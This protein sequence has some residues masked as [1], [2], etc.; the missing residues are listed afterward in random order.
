MNLTPDQTVEHLKES[1]AGY[2]ESQYRI[3]H[4]LIFNE[5]ADLLRKT[6]VIAQLPFIEATPAFETEDFLRDL[7]DLHPNTVPQG[8]T[9][10]VD[11]GIPISRYRLYTHQQRALLESFGNRPNLLVATGTGSGKTEAFVL[12]ILARILSEAKGWQAPAERTPIT[13]SYNETY[14]WLHSRRNERRPAAIRALILYPMNALVNDQMSRLRRILSLNNSPDWQRQTL[15]GNLIHFGMYTSLTETTGVPD[16]PHKRKRF[17]DY[18]KQLEEEWGTLSE[19]LQ[20]MGNWP[21]PNE[22]EML[23][24]WDMQ[25]APP[26]ILV[27]NYSMLEYTL[28]RHIERDM[29]D[30]T[31]RWL[32][33]SP[34]NKFTLV[35]DEAHTYTGAKGTEVAHLIRRLKE[36]L[37]IQE[38]DDKLRAIATS[39]SIPTRQQDGARQLRRF[40]ADL[41]GETEESFT[42]IEANVT[43]LKGVNRDHNEISMRAF[44]D[45]HHR[46]STENPWPAMNELARALG[47]PPPNGS[48]D[49]QVAMFSL[50][51]DNEDVRWLRDRTARNA[52]ILDDLSKEFWPGEDCAEDRHQ[53]TSGALAAGAFARPEPV[54]DIQPLLSMRVH[55][56]FRGLTG[57]WACMNPQCPEIDGAYQ[58]ERPLGKLYGDPRV[59]CECGMRVLE[60]FTCR[61][62]GL[63]FLGGFP[64]SGLGSL[65]PWVDEFKDSNSPKENEYIIFGVERPHSDYPQRHRSMVTTRLVAQSLSD[66]RSTYE[67]EPAKDWQTKEEVVPYPD[68]C[69][70]CQNYRYGGG[71]SD[72]PREIIESLSTRGPRSISVVIEDSL[73]VQPTQNNDDQFNAKA[74]IFSDSRQNAAQLAGDLRRDHRNDVFRQLLYRTLHT[75][76]LCSGSGVVTRKAPYVIGQALSDAEVSCTTCSGSGINPVPLPMSFGELRREVLDL[77]LERSINI[78]EEVNEAAG[79]YAF[80][81][82]ENGDSAI[83]REWE[84]AFSVQLNREI[85]QEDFGLEPLGLG[86]WAVDIPDN[87]GTFD[88]LYEDETKKLLRIVTRILATEKVLLPPEPNKPWEWPH[89]ERMQ[90]YER[91]R[92]VIG[93]RAF[94]NYVPYNFGP[95][96]KLG[97]YMKALATALKK[98][99]RITIPDKWLEEQRLKIWDALKGFDILS[100]A[101]KIVN[102][103]A[104]QGIR[105]DK[106][107]LHPI[108]DSVF[109]CRECRYVMGETLFDVCYRCGQ[110]TETAPAQDI[111]NQFRRIALFSLPNSEF[112]DPYAMRAAEHTAQIERREA[113]SIE[114]W[115][116]D[117]F[118]PEEYPADHRVDILSV[119][120]TMEMG[121]DIGSLLSVGLRNMAPNVANYQQRSGRAGRRGSSLATVITYC[122]HR[123][124]DQYYFQ[125]PREIIS[126]PPRAPALYLT[127]EVIARRHVRS[128]VLTEFFKGAAP[129]PNSTHLFRVWGTTGVFL[130][131]GGRESLRKR[132]AADR[133]I[134]IQRSKCVVHQSFHRELDAW[135][136][137]MPEEIERAAA[138]SNYDAD[139]LETLIQKG[140]APKYAFPVDVVRLSIPQEEDYEEPY[141]SQDY[142]SGNTRDRKIAITEYAPGAEVLLSRFPNTFV[143]SVAAVYDP[144]AV[145]PNY[146]PNE[147]LHEC[148]NCRALHISTTDDSGNFRQCIECGDTD[149]RTFRCLIPAGF[150]VDNAD[151]DKARRPYTQSGRARAGFS[152]YAQMLVG[153]GAFQSGNKAP[154]SNGLW[155]NVDVGDLAM[156]NSGPSS[157]DSDGFR[158]CPDCGRMLE[159]GETFHRYPSD[160]PP[161]FGTG[162]GP[163]AG[164][165][166]PNRTGDVNDLT[167]LHRFSSEVITLAVDLPSQLDAPFTDESGR[168]IWHSSATLIKEAAARTLQIDQNEIQSGIRPIR[169]PQGRIQG[170]IFIY[171][172]VPGGAG[173]ARAIHDN[174]EEIMNEALR[175]SRQCSNLDCEDACY[176]CILAYNNQLIHKY[177]DRNLG[178]SFIEFVMTGNMP[179]NN[180]SRVDFSEDI[181]DYLSNS[182]W[183]PAGVAGRFTTPNGAAV[184]IKVIHP[185]MSRPSRDA[186]IRTFTTFDVA[187]RPFWVA[188]RLLKE[189]S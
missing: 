7:E 130:Q 66:S 64:D 6:G 133:E 95:Y 85:T 45:F 101:G 63:L 50:L 92:L 35:L 79:K 69:P 77:Q 36:R 119:T 127:N 176:H 9:E 4:P 74:L 167:L 20:P 179:P 174:L 170:E 168:A 137:E 158:I 21:I 28:I 65:W 134:F 113:R 44:A 143:Y 146:T 42:V 86:M 155:S 51:K 72:N 70:R 12:P 93:Q 48:L 87:S 180:L 5:R 142:Y 116:Q 11:H 98:S 126:E 162:K 114:R 131:R 75:C 61:K 160:V 33:E 121:I 96:R 34:E 175:A 3:S 82:I 129:K 169:D 104:P 91:R 55:I 2:L 118:L 151:L 80:K 152:S 156:S 159:D 81:R 115:F 164:A 185:L 59:R 78:A 97:R 171:D 99:G 14:G 102:N 147:T 110:S 25:S 154:W 88:G 153:Q 58:G 46:F 124:H 10:L 84:T 26:D 24:R 32:A 15:N 29:F 30:S 166:C 52:T 43:E 18:I 37:G 68:R 177:L 23:C 122:L 107:V 108:G 16:N 39:A 111:R 57:I 184:S 94:D 41:F 40:T 100:N 90:R 71:D 138:E 103:Q 38:G 139:L 145:E 27:T 150:S 173:Y 178:R 135:L 125:N 109:R 183:R 188:D 62:C 120:T 181:M 161:H 53:A 13:P 165:P 132:L 189:F 1:L 140:L 172:D 76:R 117:L 163:R 128:L 105:I 112:P 49:P 67:I 106:F 148:M 54:P 136:A 186:T 157:E 56:F 47:L 8:L 182:G 19:D 83:M 31:R 123:S 149:L 141:E 144:N 187:K 22:S 17:N 73:R 60:V 89:D